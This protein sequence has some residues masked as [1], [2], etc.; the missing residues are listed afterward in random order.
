MTSNQSEINYSMN[1]LNVDSII[2]D[3]KVDILRAN[4]QDIKKHVLYVQKII[5]NVK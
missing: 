4:I 5:Q 1:D 2:N 3:L